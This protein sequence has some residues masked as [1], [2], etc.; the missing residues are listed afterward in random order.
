MTEAPTKPKRRERRIVSRKASRSWNSAIDP[1]KPI[2]MIP[3]ARAANTAVCFGSV[4]ASASGRMPAEVAKSSAPRLSATRR[5]C[6]RAISAMRKKAAAVSTI[7]SILVVPG[8]M[9]RSASTSSTISASSWTC[10]ALSVL[11]RA[12]ANTPGPTAAS[13]SRTAMRNGRLLR[14]TTSAP[15]RATSCAASG[16]KVRARSF[17]LGAT[18]SSR[19]RMIASAPRRAAPSTKRRCV[20]GTNSIE[21]HTGRFW[22]IVLG[23]SLVH[24]YPRTAFPAK[25]GIHAGPSLGR[26]MV[27]PGCRR[28][29]GRGWIRNFSF[30]RLG[31]AEPDHTLARQCL[32]RLPVDAELAE[33]LGG[34]LAEAGGR[35]AQ[36]AG[37]LAEARDDV[38]HRQTAGL[39]VRHI[40]DDLARQDM[41]V[42]EELVDVVDRRGGDLGRGKGGHVFVERA[43]GDECDDRR[44]AFRGVLH[45][46]SVVAK[47]R[48]GD[49][50]LAP[51]R[52]EQPLGH[53]LDRGGDAD[54]AAV[55][56]AEHVA[57]GSRLR[58]AAGARADLAGQIVDRRLGGDE[59]KERVE[60]RK[61]NDL[62]GAALDL[63][64]AQRDHDGKGAIEPGDHVCQRGRR[65]YRLPIG[66]AG[67]RG[68][69]RHAL[70]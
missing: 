46:V 38:V 20:T 1:I 47:A 3:A 25:A 64:P 43:R 32:Q 7:A 58:A 66:K 67:A 9:P 52:A 17:S 48:V 57:W 4:S 34:V 13:M 26:R 60:Q 61:I 31:L 54:I 15:P 65:Q 42:G 40:D 19:S 70:D 55:L 53:R 14:T 23:L 69:A 50:V 35:A 22:V 59:R 56:G 8:G 24:N 12:S 30:R 18:L 41:R 21:R 49:D 28:E 10:S 63:D 39:R 29:C 33:D 6:A 45:P 27:D 2:G 44:L 68:I 5:G 36:V 16:T 62:P 11:G 51:D 37:R